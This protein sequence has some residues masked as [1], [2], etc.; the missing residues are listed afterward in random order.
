[1]PN[2][3]FTARDKH[4]QWH[5]GTQAADSAAALA[6]A[7][8][9]LGWSLVNARPAEGAAVAAPGSAPKRRIGILPPAGLDVEFG[10]RMLANMLEGGV[11]LLAALKTCA[12][13]ARRVRMGNI[14]IAVHDRVAGGMPFAE[15]LAR[16]P[17]VFP[18]LVIQLVRAGELSG[19]LEIVLEQAADQLERKRNLSV[20]VVSALMYPTFATVVA[21]GV[22]AFL[23]IKI[24]PDI[25]GFLI[26]QGRKLPAMTQALISTSQFVTGY[27]W[28]ISITLG[29]IFLA[30][31]IIHKWPP[32]ALFIDR[33]LLHIPLVGKIFRLAGT[34]MFARGFGMLLE[35]GVPVL[36]A[37]DT[38]GGLMKNR[39]IAERVDHARRAVLAGSALARPLAAGRE[40]MPMLP[41]MVAIGEETG[42]LSN[43]LAKV[44]NFH[45]KQ[46]E[47]YI[48]RMTLLIEPIMT[49]VVGT[50][51]GFVYL[52]FFMAVYSTVGAG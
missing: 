22:T 27:F 16:H 4:G 44:A 38:A 30:L 24:I 43:V 12:D 28:P 40:F 9:A 11:T 52:A 36:A 18:Q 8:R 50:I 42:T 17:R 2:F 39:A 35:A 34:T 37:L 31:I 29:A 32:G 41:R 21:V 14:W 51:V 3:T 26:S 1:M 45:E 47:S 7:I 15:A 19:N 10:L 13:Q 5:N 46:L 33:V 6:L 20:A 48:K 25:S 49:V 23:L